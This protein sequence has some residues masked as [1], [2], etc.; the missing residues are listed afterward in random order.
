MYSYF[1]FQVSILLR[2]QNHLGAMAPLASNER[3][4]YSV[5]KI[6]SSN[7]ESTRAG[8]KDF[9]GLIQ[10]LLKGNSHVCLPQSNYC[11][12]TVNIIVK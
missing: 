11:Y 12:V 4:Q 3:F 9:Q 10:G 6:C 2:N 7:V 8:K 1:R 5:P